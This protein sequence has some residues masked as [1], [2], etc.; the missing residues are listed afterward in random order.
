[1]GQMKKYEEELKEAI[2]TLNK[3]LKEDVQ[4]WLDT[5]NGLPTYEEVKGALHPTLKSRSLELAEQWA[6]ESAD[7]A[8]DVAIARRYVMEDEVNAMQAEL[9]LA[10]V[11]EFPKSVQMSIH[12]VFAW[13]DEA[14]TTDQKLNR[15]VQISM[16]LQYPTI[17]FYFVNGTKFRG[18]RFGVDGPDY[19]SM[20]GGE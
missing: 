2:A 20:Y 15:Y 10:Q 3:S 4:K 12:E 1:M 7:L 16:A 11:R 6:K 5:A 9:W 8:E 14:K 19:M 18:F 13:C 17:V